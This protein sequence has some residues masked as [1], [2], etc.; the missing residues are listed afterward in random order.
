LPKTIWRVRR[1]SRLAANEWLLSDSTA[2]MK[3]GA[4]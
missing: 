2:I 4:H 1:S 3:L